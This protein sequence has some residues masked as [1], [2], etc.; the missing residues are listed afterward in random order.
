MTLL[1]TDVA[2]DVLRNHPPAIAWLQSLGGAPL[3][4]PGPVVMELLQ[5]NSSV[6][7]SSS[8]HSRCIGHRAPT[9]TARCRISLRST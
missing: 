9:V 4:L 5:G 8:G 6:S 7:N 2:V 1:D 3:G